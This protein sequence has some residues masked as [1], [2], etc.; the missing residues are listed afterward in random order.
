MEGL[1]RFLVIGRKLVG[2]FCFLNNSFHIR[3]GK[4]NHE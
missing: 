3:L 4:A 2:Y 1:E